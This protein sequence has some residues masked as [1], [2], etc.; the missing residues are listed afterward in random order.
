[1]QRRRDAFG[2][3]S[4]VLPGSIEEDSEQR[5]AMR[6]LD[7][8]GSP[9]LGDG[10]SFLKILFRQPSLAYPGTGCRRASKADW[11]LMTDGVGD[12]SAQDTELLDFHAVISCWWKLERIDRKA[13]IRL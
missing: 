7:A 4:Q 2:T 5:P 10:E 1:M 3:L 12:Q 11:I 13:T 9:A 6:H 8:A